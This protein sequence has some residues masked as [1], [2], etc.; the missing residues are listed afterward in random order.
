ILNWTELDIW[1]YIRREGIPVVPLYFARNGQ[2]YRSLGEK[3][4]TFPID[5][6]AS[7]I[8]EIIAELEVTTAPERAG[9]SMD[10]ESEDAFER[11]RQGGYM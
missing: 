10:H 4:I 11:L 7:T 8:D 1:H 3:N 2:R 6:N 9:R 5:S